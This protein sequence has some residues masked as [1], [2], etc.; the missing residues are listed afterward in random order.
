MEN[1]NIEQQS[2][3]T[4]ALDAAF[5]A[6]FS[7]APTETPETESKESSETKQED[8]KEQQQEKQAE[9]EHVQITR[10]EWDALQSKLS[11]IDTLRSSNDKA[12]GKIGGIERII[13]QFQQQTPSGQQVEITDDDLKELSAEYPEL[14]QGMLKSLQK[15][16]GKLKGTGGAA[17]I[18]PSEIEKIVDART[19]AKMRPDEQ[20]ELEVLHE[21]HPDWHQTIWKDQQA[22]VKQPEFA[23]WLNTLPKSIARKF[24]NSMDGEYIASKLSQFKAWSAEKKAAAAK[25]EADKQQSSKTKT[26]TRMAAA[27]Q[28]RSGGATKTQAATTE[29][30]GLNAGFYS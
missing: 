9:P 26:N 3:E 11:E 6:G 14:A 10:Q 23:E 5:E 1:E 12:F 15:I 13:Q 29:D 2:E 20:S 28:P 30:E 25:A 22:G 27:V 24:E 18:D 21:L 16:A 17:P 19:A 4:A 7:G 8:Q